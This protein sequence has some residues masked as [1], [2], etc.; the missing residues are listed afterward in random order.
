MCR[1]NIIRS[2]SSYRSRLSIVL[3]VVW[4]SMRVHICRMPSPMISTA[5][6]PTAIFVKGI[7]QGRKSALPATP[8]LHT[9][10]GG[11]LRKFQWGGQIGVS[12]LAYKRLSINANLEWGFN[13][14]FNS[15]FKTISFSLYP[16]Y[17]NLGF[18]YNF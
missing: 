17:L 4:F 8:R 11:D 7:R 18:G 5:L 16:I 3:T 13:S 12:W 1:Q 14:I 15:S 9:T 10:S 2:S 6:S